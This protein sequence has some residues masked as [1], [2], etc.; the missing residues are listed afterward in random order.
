MNEYNVW[1]NK[2]SLDSWNAENSSKRLIDIWALSTIDHLYSSRMRICTCLLYSN[3]LFTKTLIFKRKKSGLLSYWLLLAVMPIW[4]LL[5]VMPIG[6]CHCLWTMVVCSR[7]IWIPHSSK[8][9]PSSRFQRV[10]RIV[11]AF[12]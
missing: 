2:A 1:S 3:T 6:S 10:E 5:V 9:Y 7:L 12:R 8:W 11:V 4:L